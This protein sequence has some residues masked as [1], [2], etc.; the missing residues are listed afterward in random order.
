[1]HAVHLQTESLTEPLGLGVSL[2]RFSWHCENGTEQ[3]AYRIVVS[4]GGN[5]LWDSG[6]VA[7]ASRT[8]IRYGGEPLK[9]RQRVSWSVTLWDEADLEGPASSSCF[10]MGLLDAQAWSAKW[11]TSPEKQDVKKPSR[12]NSGSI[13]IWISRLSEWLVVSATRKVW[14]L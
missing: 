4:S 1:M 7:S 14:I 6:K 3:T 10:E 8:W 12:G 13:S 11:I 5:T 2:P 9:S